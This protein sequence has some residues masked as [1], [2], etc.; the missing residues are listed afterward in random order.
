MNKITAFCT[1]ALLALS[2]SLCAQTFEKGT[3]V[4]SA[5][6]G[7]GSALGNYHHSSQSPALSLQYERGF[8]E[9]GPG[10][11]SLGAYA[12]RKTYKYSYKY[13]SDYTLDEKW[14]YTVI[15]IRGAWHY[16]QLPVEKL[17]VYGGVMLAY[18]ILKYSYT[19]NGPDGGSY[20]NAGNYGSN[21]G[22]SAYVGGRYY[23]LNN[24][25]GFAE[26]GYGVSYL[27][28]GLSLKF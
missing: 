28:F 15:G 26:A 13:Y 18:N 25:A 21:A 20:Y 9:A 23:F 7:L 6:I 22:F 27:N 16:T 4:L 2:T 12:G 11:V 3:N 14:S 19:D 8:W 24:L 17:D 1:T 5:G 10:V